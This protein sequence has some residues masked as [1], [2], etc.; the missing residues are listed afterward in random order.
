M[1][2]ELK[3]TGG[4]RYDWHPE[5]GEPFEGIA[6]DI[7]APTNTPINAQIADNKLVRWDW[8]DRHTLAMIDQMR[9]DIALILLREEGDIRPGDQEMIEG[10]A[11]ALEQFWSLAHDDL[12]SEVSVTPYVAENTTVNRPGLNFTWESIR[13]QLEPQHPEKYNNH[14]YWHG[15]GGKNDANGLAYRWSRRAWTFNLYRGHRGRRRTQQHENGHNFIGPHSSGPNR[16][17][18]PDCIMGQ[19]FCGPNASAR[20]SAGIIRDDAVDQLEENGVMFLAPIE[21]SYFDLRSGEKHA[22]LIT[23][24]HPRH[25]LST[26]KNRNQCQ[27]GY[28]EVGQVHVHEFHN[29]GKQNPI[30]LGKIMP[31]E[32]RDVGG[33]EVRNVGHENG[34]VKIST[35]GDADWPKAQEPISGDA[36]T[37][38]LSGIWHD[39]RYKHQGF[40]LTFHDGKLTGYWYGHHPRGKH[41]Q[42]DMSHHSGRRW[43]IL[44]GHDSGGYIEFEAW[45]AD[46]GKLVEQGKGTIRFDGDTALLRWQTGFYGREHYRL[47]RVSP[48][49]INQRQYSFGDHSGISACEYDIPKTDEQG[50]VKTVRVT[51]VFYFGPGQGGQ[52]WKYM[53]GS[54]DSLT[55]YGMEQQHRDTHEGEVKELGVARIGGDEF[56]MLGRTHD[57][58]RFL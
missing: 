40:D 23:T 1:L 34:V 47:T 31:G 15:V 11:L 48:P 53:D 35:G 33:L 10:D 18:G 12:W 50:R 3:Q 27:L 28:G 8:S 16:E 54:P 58:E 5:N 30:Y 56:E 17:Y 57:M 26:R 7:G 25:L 6:N 55:V 39:S 9:K 32:S 43:M 19:G 4:G 41:M 13:D 22:A 52:D 37:E 51:F 2:G 38:S 21:S 24:G 46:G 49:K 42:S 44:Q 45:S 14:T 29:G 20:I 36:I